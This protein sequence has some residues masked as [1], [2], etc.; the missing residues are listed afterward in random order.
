[1]DGE[2][3]G[4]KISDGVAKAVRSWSFVI[5]Q[6]TFILLW[7]YINRHGSI[8]LWDKYPFDMLKL[9]LTIEASFTASMILMQQNRQAKRDREI[10]YQDHAIQLHIQQ[11]FDKI[12]ERLPK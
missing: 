2:K 8:Y 12:K 3:L 11:E 6:M 7:I 5:C 10:L 1:M 9:I 4:Q